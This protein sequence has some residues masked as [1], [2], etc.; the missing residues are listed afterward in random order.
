M[1]AS[2]D[3]E[4]KLKDV[5]FMTHPKPKDDLQARTWSQLIDGTLA[6][7]DTW[8]VMRSTGKMNWSQVINQVFHK[9]GKTNNYF[10]ILRNLRNCLTAD[11]VT[12]E[13][14]SL[15]CSMLKDKEAII[16]SMVLPFRYLSAYTEIRNINT[17]HD[18]SDIN[19]AMEEAVKISIDNVPKL[20]GTSVIAIDTSGSMSGVIAN[21]STV[22]ASSIA[23]MLGMMSRRICDKSRTVTFDTT[24][25]WLNLP[26][27][28]ILR[29]AY[30]F[31]APGG[32]TYGHLVLDDMIREQY[33]ADRVIF[34][35]DMVLYE[36]YGYRE[37]GFAVS[38]MK[39][40]QMFPKSRLY[41]VDLRGYGLSTVSEKLPSARNVAGWSDRT[42]EMVSLLEKGTTA[43]DEIQKISL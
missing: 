17:K 42:I 7:P 5:L 23:M 41:N 20:P 43:I 1:S 22:S 15:L 36:E 35:T 14:V 28:G 13:D 18:I 21:K 39:Y 31:D 24:Q 19:E 4:V 8:E 16:H 26:D 34:L 27:K 3:G 11:D 33:E 38:W 9:D 2:K 25:K 12:S 29:N 32:A 6:S 40:H 10:A 30:E 37:G